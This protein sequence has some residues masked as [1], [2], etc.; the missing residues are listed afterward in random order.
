MFVSASVIKKMMD[1][2][3][4]RKLLLRKENILSSYLRSLNNPSSS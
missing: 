3:K 2:I 1:I 4:E